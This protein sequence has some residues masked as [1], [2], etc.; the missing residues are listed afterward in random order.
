MPARPSIPSWYFTV[1]AHPDVKLRKPYRAQVV[2]GKAERARLWELGEIRSGDYRR[3][4][5]APS[6]GDRQA[7]PPASPEDQGPGWVV[8]AAADP[9]PSSV[10][11]VGQPYLEEGISQQSDECEGL[12]H[13]SACSEGE[14]FGSSA[15]FSVI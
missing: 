6:E 1:L 3:R 12:D 7:D 15:D 8:E 4:T 9:P 13:K 5:G 14:G 11:R 10:N 2:E